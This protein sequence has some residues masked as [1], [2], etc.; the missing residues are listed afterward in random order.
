MDRL[1]G[2]IVLQVIC[3]LYIGGRDNHYDVVGVPL[4]PHAVEQ[5]CKDP[6]L[7][8]PHRFR[9]TTWLAYLYIY[10]IGYLFAGGCIVKRL[11]SNIYNHV[12]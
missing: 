9:Y 1:M 6:A 10:Q 5:G 7:D 2:P 8:L 11:V 4:T 3:D 12:L